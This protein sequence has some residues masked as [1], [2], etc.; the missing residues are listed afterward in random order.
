M[1]VD[2]HDSTDPQRRQV[3]ALG[4]GLGTALALP[5]ADWAPAKALEGAVRAGRAAA[6]GVMTGGGTGAKGAASGSPTNTP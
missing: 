1:N 5:L 6:Q 3:L 2:A 4:A